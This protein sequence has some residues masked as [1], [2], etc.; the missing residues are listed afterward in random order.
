MLSPR[1]HGNYSGPAV[2][3]S[4]SQHYGREHDSVVNDA[5]PDDSF[6][7]KVSNKAKAAYICKAA[8]VPPR[9]FYVDVAF[10]VEDWAVSGDVGL[11]TSGLY[12]ADLRRQFYALLLR[13]GLVAE[14]SPA[15]AEHGKA[16]FW[17]HAF[18]FALARRTSGALP[19]DPRV[20]H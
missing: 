10:P 7:S 18:N 9:A 20:L 4:Y 3:L 13:E 19:I 8:G 1:N 2:P 16:E 14:N 11:I 17:A 15:W 12:L 5:E 6:Y